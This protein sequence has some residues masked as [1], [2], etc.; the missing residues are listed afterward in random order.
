LITYRSLQNTP[1]AAATVS[2]H[3]RTVAY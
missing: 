1:A 2:T 3:I